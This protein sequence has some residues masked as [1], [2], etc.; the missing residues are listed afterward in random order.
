MLTNEQINDAVKDVLPDVLAGL[1]KQVTEQALYQAQQAMTAAVN[2]SV[3]EW[4]IENLVPEI[5]ASLTESKDGLIAFAPRMA[6]SV[7]MALSDAI[8]ETLKKKLENQWERKKIFEALI[9]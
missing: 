1:K 5:H 3:T 7:T 9:A 8:V 6:E 4:V 2:K